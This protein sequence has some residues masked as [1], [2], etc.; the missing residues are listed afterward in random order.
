MI[1]GD[2][3]ELYNTDITQY[4]S[5]AV[6]DMAPVM[7]VKNPNGQYVRNFSENYLKNGPYFNSG[8]L[9]IN[10]KKYG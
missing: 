9:L 6:I 10:T 3:A 1:L 5:G 7:D 2:L 4:A 8:V